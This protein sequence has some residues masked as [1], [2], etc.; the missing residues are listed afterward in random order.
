[1]ERIEPL[2]LMDRIDPSDRRDKTEG[3]RASG[4]PPSWRTRSRPA[5]DGGRVQLSLDARLAKWTRA[6]AG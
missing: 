1:M 6:G 2:E 5:I 3:S 4:T